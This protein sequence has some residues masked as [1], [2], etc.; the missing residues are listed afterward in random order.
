MQLENFDIEG[1]LAEY[2]QQKPLLIKNALPDFVNPL[3]PEE[4]AGLACEAG[5]ES[6][7]ITKNNDDWSQDSGPFSEADFQSLPSADSTLLV[8]AVNHWVPEVATLLELF[9]FLPNWRIDD[10]MVS[11]ATSGGSVGPHYD[12]YDVFL[13]QGAGTREWQVGPKNSSQS[14]LRENQQLRLL[15]E[16]EADETW[17]LGPGDIL[18]IPPL[19]G[20]WG[21]AKDNDCMTYSVGFRAPS[22]AEL[23]AHYCDER[24]SHLNDDLRYRDIALSKS[25]TPGEINLQVVENIQQVL[26]DQLSDPQNIAEWFGRYMTEQKYPTEDTLD[27]HFFSAQTINQFLTEHDFLMRDETSRFAHTCMENKHYLYVNGQSYDCL[28]NSCRELAALLSNNSHYSTERISSFVSDTESFQLL[29]TLLNQGSV[30]FE[31]SLDN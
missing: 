8:Q 17:L 2:W 4:L 13:L 14:P 18:Y 26:T 31:E 29:Q 9:R 3:S 25:D 12:N 22:H 30:Y 5:V 1:F 24:L 16:F 15:R 6:R 23:L 10:I 11:Y 21:T 28:S 7:I 19:Y 27:D 20:H